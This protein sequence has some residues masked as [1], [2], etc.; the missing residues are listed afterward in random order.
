V[1]RGRAVVLRL[2]PDT[3]GHQTH[4]WPAL[5]RQHLVDLL[6]RSERPSAN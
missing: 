5:W 3:R 4:T 6:E 2:S 1:K